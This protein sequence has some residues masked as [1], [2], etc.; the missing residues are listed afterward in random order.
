MIKR[1]IANKVHY[2]NKEEYEMREQFFLW[3]G[4]KSVHFLFCN[5]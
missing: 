4:I 5:W 3:K 1:E 2:T